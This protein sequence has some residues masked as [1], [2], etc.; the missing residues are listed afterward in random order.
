[1]LPFQEKGCE[2]VAKFWMSPEDFLELCLQSPYKT[3]IYKEEYIIS[4]IFKY[5]LYFN[6]IYGEGGYAD[7]CG[8]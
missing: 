3:T 6:Y 1:M 4:G 5:L 8:G 7:A 2:C